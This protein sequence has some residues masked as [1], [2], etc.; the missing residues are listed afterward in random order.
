M[1]KTNIH[2]TRKLEKLAK[3][4]ISKDCQGEASA[5]GKWNANL[6]YL[7]RKKYWLV[8][9]GLTRYNVVLADIKAAD[10]VNIDNIFLKTLYEQLVYDGVSID[11][12]KLAAF[13]G[14]LCFLPTDN[15]RVVAG[16]QNQR[17]FELSVWMSYHDEH[18]TFFIN[19]SVNKMNDSPI[20]FG[21][22]NGF[23]DSIAAMRS[24]LEK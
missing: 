19:E 5:L 18:N 15:D 22:G 14:G 8:S 21:K 9:N 11:L 23:T 17:L 6:F 1:I 20:Q 4:L 3:K 16:L 24:I 2:T 12:E 13:I 7:E 10:H